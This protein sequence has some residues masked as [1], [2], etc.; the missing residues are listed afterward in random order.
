MTRD[1]FFRIATT[2]LGIVVVDAFRGLQQGLPVEHKIHQYTTKRFVKHLV[3]DLW[4]Q[5]QK[6]YSTGTSLA[7]PFI[8]TTITFDNSTDGDEPIDSGTAVSGV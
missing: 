7:Q 5:S 4:T 8:G 6:S 3:G 2:I 1:G